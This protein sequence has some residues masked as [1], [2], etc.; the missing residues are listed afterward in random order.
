VLIHNEDQCFGSCASEAA[1]TTGDGM[2]KFLGQ[3]PGTS[4]LRRQSASYGSITCIGGY[5]TRNAAVEA[6]SFGGDNPPSL[7]HMR[8]MVAEYIGDTFPQV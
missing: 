3:F 7:E 8:L 4:L 5:A 2:D 6:A 1:D